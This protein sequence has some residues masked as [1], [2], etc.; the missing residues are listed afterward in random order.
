MQWIV[1][2]VEIDLQEAF[3][4]RF[5]AWGGGGRVKFNDLSRNDS[6]SAQARVAQARVD[7][8]PFL[9]SQILY[10]SMLRVWLSS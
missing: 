1:G 6:R 9:Q 5:R 3:K 10:D 4:R 7:L 8:Q 2:R